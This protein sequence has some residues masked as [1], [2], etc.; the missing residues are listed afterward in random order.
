M[1]YVNNLPPVY[2]GLGGRQVKGVVHAREVRPVERHDDAVQEAA[3]QEQ[4]D[5]QQ[6]AA[7]DQLQDRRKA[8]RR[9]A[10]QPVLVELRSGLERRHHN[11]F[12]GD[13]ADH[14]DEEA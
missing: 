5:H 9:T 14:I 8:C 4:H 6:H 13:V 7:N 12:P 3:Q 10:H 2:V 11:L 1:R